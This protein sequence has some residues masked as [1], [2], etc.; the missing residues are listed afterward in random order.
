[1]DEVF[2]QLEEAETDHMMQL[3]ERQQEHQ[4]S[5]AP[6]ERPVASATRRPHSRVAG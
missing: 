4:A 2:D 6:T 5:Q 3:W 1:M